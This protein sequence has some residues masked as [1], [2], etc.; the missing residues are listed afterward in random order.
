MLDYLSLPLLIL[1]SGMHVME[2]QHATAPLV[3]SCSNASSFQQ[4]SG[5]GLMSL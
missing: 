2:Y 5:L 3:V 4:S 1:W